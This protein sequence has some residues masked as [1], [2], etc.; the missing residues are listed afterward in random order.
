VGL[1]SRPCSHIPTFAHWRTKIMTTET[2][3]QVEPLLT[4][5]TPATLLKLTKMDF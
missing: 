4:V 5:P 1:G 3:K 2:T